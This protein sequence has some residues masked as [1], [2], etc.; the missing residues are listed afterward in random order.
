M[1]DRTWHW[2]LSGYD[3]RVHAFPADERPASFVHAAC[4]QTVPYSKLARTH[5][6]AR[7]LPC[8]LVIGD[9]LARR[10]ARSPV[11]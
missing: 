10:A 1:R 11:D 3:G 4:E 8:L 6:G 5:A 7:C 2:R 9:E